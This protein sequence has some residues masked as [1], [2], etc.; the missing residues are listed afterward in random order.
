MTAI[1]VPDLTTEVVGG[2]GVFDKLMTSAKAH[3]KEEYTN[4]RITGS[5]YAEV[6][7]G[8]MNAV[9]QQS[10]AFLLGMAQAEAQANLTAAQKLL[11][12]QQVLNAIADNDLK[13]KQ[14]EK[15]DTEIALLKQKTKSEKAQI[16]DKVDCNLV[17][18]VIGKQKAL[19]H[20]QTEGFS[21]DAE[22]KLMKAMVD[23]WAVRRTTDDGTTVSANG[24]S[25]ANIKAVIDAARN[26]IGLPN[27][28]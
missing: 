17:A 3:L 2:T 1:T 22:Q 16:L 11:T 18:G 15:I 13:L 21:R 5:S 4:G 23:T 28:A 27:S 12:D 6:Y 24:L 20:A 19:Y 14:A 7:L 8:S 26:G 10:T 25:D 9:M